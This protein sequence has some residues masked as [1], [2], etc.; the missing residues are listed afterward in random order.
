MDQPGMRQEDPSYLHK[1][2]RECR[3]MAAYASNHGIAVEPWIPGVLDEVEVVASKN[4]LTNGTELGS[5][6]SEPLA[7]AHNI[8]ARDVPSSSSAPG[9]L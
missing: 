6:F 9:R 3:A 5:R 4:G 8:L 1:L 7:R 2:F